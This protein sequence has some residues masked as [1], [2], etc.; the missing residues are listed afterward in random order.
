[1]EAGSEKRNSLIVSS[2]FWSQ[3]HI[4]SGL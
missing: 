3:Q 1:M 2:S 4:A